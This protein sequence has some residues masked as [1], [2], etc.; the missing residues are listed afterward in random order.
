M[1]KIDPA[2]FEKMSG[3][4]PLHMYERLIKETDRFSEDEVIP[5]L[6]GL[7]GEVGSIMSASK[8]YHRE[9]KAYI[10]YKE[11][12]EEE[13]GDAL[14]YF[15]ALCGRMHVSISDVFDAAIGENA[16]KFISANDQEHAPISQ[17]VTAE[18]VESLDSSLLEL[19]YITAQLLNVDGVSDN[20]KQ[21]L[22]DFSRV[23]MK[24]LQSTKLSF[25]RIVKGNVKKSFGRFSKPIID[26]LPDFD[27]IFPEE[28]QL[29]RYFEIH[30][31]E[32]KSGQSYMR[33]NGVFIGSPLT[34]N[35]KNPDGYRFHDVF[36]FAYAAI[37][38][39]SPT[40]RALIKHKRKSDPACDE[41][42]DGGRAIV[43]E[44][45][46]TA[47][48]YSYSKGLDYFDGHDGVSFDVLKTI[49]KFIQGYEV[50]DCPLKLWED[51][52]LQGY[53]VF[54][55]VKD[56]NGGVVIGDRDKR[57]LSYRNLGENNEGK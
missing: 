27:K 20:G 44:E 55:K 56:N 2:E 42:Q 53:S 21:K 14:W 25:V 4:I 13:F 19:G 46:L 51:A 32:R 10:G 12:V 7:Y 9:K 39:W 24:A 33:W 8:K 3:S 49:Q 11:A 6:L 41:A 43:V 29:P 36:H 54:R 5:I 31:S 28:E 40:F 48:I 50:E 15:T 17:L 34:D 37:L 47:W 38:H 23:Y 26:N 45:G 22:I 18:N 16:I 1:S 35:I 57:T 52:I 30:I